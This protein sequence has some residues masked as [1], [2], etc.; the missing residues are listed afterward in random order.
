MEMERARAA[1]VAAL[2]PPVPDIAQNLETI[3]KHRYTQNNIDQYSS[4]YYHIPRERVERADPN[5]HQVSNYHWRWNAPLPPPPKNKLLYVDNL[6]GGG[7]D[8]N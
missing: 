5:F 8:K 1:R 3:Q 2:E 7:E 6:W 4:T